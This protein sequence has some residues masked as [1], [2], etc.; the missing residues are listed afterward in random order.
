MKRT[1]CP[2][3]VAMAA[4]TAE[5]RAVGAWVQPE[6]VRVHGYYEAV[7]GF[8]TCPVSSLVCSVQNDQEPIPKIFSEF[9]FSWLFLKTSNKR[10]GGL[11]T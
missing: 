9:V 5:V 4:R 3:R 2:P 10:G 1:D 6:P 8:P 7:V 11:L